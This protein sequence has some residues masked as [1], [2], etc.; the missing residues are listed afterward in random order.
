MDGP[1]E[2]PA[3]SERQVAWDKAKSVPQAL[4]PVDPD[5][6]YRTMLNFVVKPE[7]MAMAFTPEFLRGAN[8]Y[9][10]QYSDGAVPAAVPQH[11]LA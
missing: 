8:G 10:A 5:S 1:V 4:Q 3:P 7:H 2:T 9:N 6:L 11:G